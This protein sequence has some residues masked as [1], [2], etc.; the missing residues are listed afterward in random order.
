MQY[1][2][3]IERTQSDIRFRFNTRTAAGV[4]VDGVGLA[5][6]VYKDGSVTEITGA[7]TLT[8]PFDSRTGLVSVYVDASG[9][10]FTPGSN[11]SVVLSAG[12][13][14]GVSVAGV[15]VA[16]F[17]IEYRNTRAN[18]IAMEPNVVTASALA[19]DAVAELQ[20]GLSTLDAAGVRS[21]VGLASANLDTQ[22]ADLPT[23]SEFNARTLASADYFVVS[24]YTSPPS[25]ATIADAVWDELQTG[26]TTI[27]SFGYYLDS[28]VSTVGGGTP[29]TASAIADAV[30]DEVLAGHLTAGTTGAALNASGGAG[31]PWSTTL[32]GA[33]TGDQ[34]GRLLADIVDSTSLITVG[35]VTVTAP[36]SEAGVI[37]ELILGDDYLA[38]NGRALTWSVTEISGMS[39]ANASCKFWMRKDDMTDSWTGTVSDGT[40]PN[41]TLSVDIANTDWGTLEAG[42]YEY[43]V[44]IIDSSNSREVTVVINPKDQRLRLRSKV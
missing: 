13:V 39:L 41:W 16:E 14:D 30:W 8:V 2:G 24:D 11:Y 19:T 38:A 12:T 25:A 26:H 18:V 33:Y 1:L 29:P 21:A 20:S 7:V 40:D 28:R 44:E 34:A 43:G 27:G 6:V 3:D 31:D 5:A 32:P 22:I 42:L 37:T 17:S 23:V 9:A 10:S 36:V 15:C 35:N 4:P